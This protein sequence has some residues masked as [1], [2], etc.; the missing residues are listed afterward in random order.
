MVQENKQVPDIALLAPLESTKTLKLPDQSG[1]KTGKQNKTI[2]IHNV[3]KIVVMNDSLVVTRLSDNS[4][5][6]SRERIALNEIFD[7]EDWRHKNDQELVSEI[8]KKHLWHDI[9]CLGT[10]R[11]GR[12]ILHRLLLGIKISLLVG[13]LA[14]MVSITIGIVLGSLAGMKGGKTDEV[15]MLLINTVWSVPTL[16]LVFA[17]VLALGR[18]IGI[19]FI[20]V[21]LTLW[22]DTAR[23]IRGQILSIREK[24]YI[25]ATEALGF[26]ALRTL[27]LHILPNIIGPIMVI[28]TA[29]FATAILLE[30]GLSYL[31]FGIQPPTPSFGTML[32]ENYGYAV[33]GKPYLALIPAF[34]I[35]FL[36]LGFNLLGNGLRDAMDTQNLN[37][38]N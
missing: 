18:G 7:N 6:G 14:V 33:T 3:H 13:L 36:V 24:Q 25:S 26:K 34:T 15:I 1:T 38:N 29:N 32:N 12:S 17:I 5:N 37:I 28:A 22:T 4:K 31:G 8:K 30:A 35:L 16:I 19:I 20:G 2:E 21:G 11:Y 27:S 9:Y 23:L 10:D